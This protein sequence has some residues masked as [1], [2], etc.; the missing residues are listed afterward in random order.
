MISGIDDPAQYMLVLF[1]DILAATRISL[2]LGT[3]DHCM[4]SRAA[5][6]GYPFFC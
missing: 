1:K 2:F 4:I 5:T 3:Q 6:L